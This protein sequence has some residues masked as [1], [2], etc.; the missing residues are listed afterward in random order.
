MTFSP[1]GTRVASGSFDGQLKIWDA[2]S[3]KVLASCD[4]FIFP[5]MAVAFS[6]NGKRV[7]S[8]GSDRAVKIW[9]AKTGKQILSL[10]GHTL[11]STV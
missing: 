9:D 11:P 6:P 10:K 3:G 8:G 4:G 2:T 5:V 7:A 1:D